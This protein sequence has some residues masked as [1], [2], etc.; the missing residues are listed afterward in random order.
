MFVSSLADIEGN[1][2]VHT[3]PL[4]HQVPHPNRHILS[5]FSFSYNA[6]VRYGTYCKSGSH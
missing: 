6:V 4:R 3:T 5:L 2:G 1:I